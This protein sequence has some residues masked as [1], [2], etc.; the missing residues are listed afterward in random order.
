MV[1]NK[2]EILYASYAQEL[3]ANKDK[4]EVAELFRHSEYKEDKLKKLEQ[5]K[6]VK[7]DIL[8]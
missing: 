2:N 1:R 6:R 5:L 8:K 7:F 3:V 4:P